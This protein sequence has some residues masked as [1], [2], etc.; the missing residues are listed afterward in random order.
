M[1]N[2][3]EA[4]KIINKYRNDPMFL[5]LQILQNHPE[6]IIE[7]CKGELK[8]WEREVLKI[9]GSNTYQLG[10]PL[11]PAVKLCRELTG[12]GIKEAKEAVEKLLGKI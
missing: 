11:I 3:I 2:Y 12:M 10:L 4:I 5:L 7:V 1:D 8:D 9:Y 6:V